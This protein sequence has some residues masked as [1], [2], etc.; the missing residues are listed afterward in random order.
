MKKKLYIVLLFLWLDTSIHPE[1][2]VETIKKATAATLGPTTD[3]LFIDL[4]QEKKNQLQKL[5][6]EFVLR[7]AK[8]DKTTS[9]LKEEIEEIENNSKALERSL[10]Y[11]PHNKYLN[12]QL[13]LNK[14]THQV[15]KDTQRG[16]DDLETLCASFIE[17]LKQFVEDPERKK[18]K[19][20]RHLEKLPYYSFDDL[21]NIN[22]MIVSLERLLAQLAEQD[23]NTQV[24]REN[25][26]RMLKSIEEDH[27]KR[28]D[29]LQNFAERYTKKRS[30]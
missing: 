25:R 10:I 24:E 23:K 11:Y 2:V 29:D 9:T 19:E 27:A 3:Q 1:G 17:I 7:L 28:L 22:N 18:F 21:D 8:K 5:Q 26:K 30:L 12:K 4:I 15:L 16:H 13:F 14:E 20:E 6:E